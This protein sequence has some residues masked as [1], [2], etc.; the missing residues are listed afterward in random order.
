MRLSYRWLSELVDLSGISA[1]EVAEKLTFHVAEV[2][3]VEALGRA[4]DVVL[5]A[6]VLTC[7]PHPN[8]DRLRVTTVDRGDGVLRTVVCGAP[9]VAAGQVICH[10]PVGATLPNGTTLALRAI[11]G[12]TSDGMICARKTSWVWGALTTGSWSWRRRPMEIVP[13][14]VAS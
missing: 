1:G 4:L 12:I 14:V 5:S 13:R 9:N 3:G 11:R 6:R 7:A 2:E 10:A 8:A